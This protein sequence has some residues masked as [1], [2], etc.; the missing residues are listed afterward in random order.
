[1]KPSDENLPTDARS[2]L[3]TGGTGFLGRRLVERLLAQGRLVTVLARHPAPDLERRGVRFVR[4]AR[5]DDWTLTAVVKG[6]VDSDAFR[7]Q[8]DLE[9]R[10][11]T[12]S[13]H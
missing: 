5:D 1:M 4:A 11:E 12:A 9:R 3:V 13:V 2:V 6:I 8:A 7:M 10:A